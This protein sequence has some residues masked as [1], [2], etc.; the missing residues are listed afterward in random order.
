VRA[1]LEQFKLWFSCLSSKTYRRSSEH[2]KTATAFFWTRTRDV[3][4]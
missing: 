1:P 2:S 3:P 4:N